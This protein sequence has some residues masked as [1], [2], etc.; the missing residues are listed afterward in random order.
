MATKHQEALEYEREKGILKQQ[1]DA[2]NE[3]LRQRDEQVRSIRM[4]NQND[5][6]EF[7]NKQK[8]DG[9]KE[10]INITGGGLAAAPYGR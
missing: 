6:R 7:L 9:P 1:Q 10:I 2:Y 8:Q 4:A 5:Y 3:K